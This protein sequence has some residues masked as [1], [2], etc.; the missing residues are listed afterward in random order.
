MSMTHRER[1]LA[2]VAHQETD[3]LPYTLSFEGDSA[4]RLDAYY[5]GPEWRGLITSSIRGVPGPDLAPSPTDEKFFTD[6][7]GIVWQMDRRP[8]YLVEPPLKEPTLDGYELPD[9]VPLF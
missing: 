8:F 7:F 4:E 3:V 9:V 6:M 5:Q 2:Q 1:V